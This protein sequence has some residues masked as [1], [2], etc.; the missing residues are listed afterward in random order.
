MY[1]VLTDHINSSMKL[2]IGYVIK[3]YSDELSARYKFLYDR[4]I[5]TADNIF[6]KIEDWAT[7]IGTQFYKEE[8]KTWNNSPCIADSVVNVTY[9]ETE[10]DHNGEY[11]TGDEETFDATISY[12]IGDTVFFGISK[13]MGFF[14]FKCK[15]K[16]V[17]LDS[18]TPHTVSRYSPIKEFKHCDSIYRI[19]KWINH[20]IEIMNKIYKL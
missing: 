2:P 5:I 9:W 10:K 18:N 3:Y 13:Q 11:I 19:E 16:T 7:R 17:A 20:N 12:E 6:S 4:G 8:Y 15:Q 1:N 14:K